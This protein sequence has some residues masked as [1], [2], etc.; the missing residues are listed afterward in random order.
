MIKGYLESISKGIDSHS[1]KYN[2]FLLL[3]G[4]NSEPAE[5]AMESFC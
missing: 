1:S 3:R 2:N 5:E 4:C